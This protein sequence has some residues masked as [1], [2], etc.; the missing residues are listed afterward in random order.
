[1]QSCFVDTWFFI[2]TFD[3]FDEHHSAALSVERR[4]SGSIFMTHDGVLMEFLAFVSAAGAMNR[5]EAVGIVRDALRR[6]TVLP[7]DR[8][9]FLRAVDRYARRPDKA[10]SLVDCM[11]MIVMEDYGIRHVL[12]NDH[13][14]RQEG[15]IVVNE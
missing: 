8:S 3:H 10:Y 14:F 2:A 13:H 11:S 5:M 7:A 9:L 4:L 1:M 6:W 15:F 12:T